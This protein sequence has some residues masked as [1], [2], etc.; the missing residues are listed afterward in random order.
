M[1]IFE[2]SKLLDAKVLLQHLRLNRSYDGEFSS[3]GQMLN[4]SNEHLYNLIVSGV[5][6]EGVG[7]VLHFYNIETHYSE[8]GVYVYP[9]Q[10][11]KGNAD[12]LFRTVVVN[13]LQLFPPFT[14]R[15][16]V[17]QQPTK[18]LAIKWLNWDESKIQEV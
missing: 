9:D 15:K 12:S 17:M 7:C 3:W 6:I 11:G 8:L 1:Y 14:E 13:D 5:I 10:R 16:T 18:D 2:N 4:C